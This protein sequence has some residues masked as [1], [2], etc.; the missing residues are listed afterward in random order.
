MSQSAKIV[1]MEKPFEV[2][3]YNK[4]EMYKQMNVSKYIFTKWVKALEPTLGRVLGGVYNVRQ[5]TLIIETY[6]VPFQ[7][8]NQA[9]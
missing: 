5:V 6:G 3:P 1:V 9:A 7:I 2:R 4:K 8:V